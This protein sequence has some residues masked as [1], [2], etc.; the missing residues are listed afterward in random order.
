MTPAVRRCLAMSAGAMVLAIVLLAAGVPGAVLLGVA[1][2]LLCV[3]M[4]MLMGHGDPHGGDL[5][6]TGRR[7]S[8]PPTRSRSSVAHCR[9]CLTRYSPGVS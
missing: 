7:P 9:A 3:A 8:G 1:P 6:E 5:P 2:A 4:H